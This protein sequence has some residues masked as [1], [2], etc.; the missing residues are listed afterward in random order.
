MHWYKRNGKRIHGSTLARNDAID[1]LRERPKDKPFALNVAFYPPKAVGKDYKKMFSPTQESSE[2]YRDVHVPEPHNMADSWEQLPRE[3][4]VEGKEEARR[5]FY[6]RF[7]TNE[8]YQ[9]VMMSYYACITDVD[10]ASQGIW[11]E[12]ERQDLLKNTLVIF[13]TDNGFFHGEH[14]LAGKWYPYQ[15]SIRVPLIIWDPRTFN[16][17]R[18]PVTTCILLWT[19]CAN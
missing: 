6:L 11:E 9:M 1:F 18:V 14:G 4:F 10:R 19:A 5:R 7:D 3:I 17:S 8:K 13:T 2:L 15:E 16:L 12:L